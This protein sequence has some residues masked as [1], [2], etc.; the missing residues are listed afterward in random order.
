MM[1]LPL[2]SVINLPLGTN[3]PWRPVNEDVDH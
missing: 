3:K 1:V 2:F